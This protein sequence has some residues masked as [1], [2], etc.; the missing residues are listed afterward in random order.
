[1]PY[2][3]NATTLTHFFDSSKDPSI[4]ENAVVEFEGVYRPSQG[5]DYGFENQVFEV[6]AMLSGEVIEIRDDSLMG[7]SVT[8]QSKEVLITYQSLSAVSVE[9]GQQIAQHALIGLAG[10]NLYNSSLGIHLHVVAEKEG[11]L[12]DPASLIGLKISELE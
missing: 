7:K 3:I 9:E 4:L 6:N 8:V 12:I 10:E 11:K 2:T 5:V 1:M